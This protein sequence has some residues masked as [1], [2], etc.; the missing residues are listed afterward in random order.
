LALATVPSE[1]KYLNYTGLTYFNRI[2][3]AFS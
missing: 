2:G 1:I 3:K